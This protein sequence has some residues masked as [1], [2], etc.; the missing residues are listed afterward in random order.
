[1]NEVQRQK[2]I[3][4]LERKK[5]TEKKQHLAYLYRL[6]AFTMLHY[7]GVLLPYRV[8]YDLIKKEHDGDFNEVMPNK[9]YPHPGLTR[10]TA[11]SRPAYTGNLNGVKAGKNGLPDFS[12]EAEYREKLSSYEA[13]AK[14]EEMPS[15][16]WGYWYARFLMPYDIPAFTDFDY[17]GKKPEDAE[18]KGVIDNIRAACLEVWHDCKEHPENY[19]FEPIPRLEEHKSLYDV[20]YGYI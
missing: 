10:D 18:E 16:N 5:E 1:M 2:A 12:E 13:R 15:E 7:E 17:W 19:N 14:A 8:L 9:Y 3:E 20:P 11:D 6:A 4:A